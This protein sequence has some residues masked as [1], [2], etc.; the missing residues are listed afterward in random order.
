MLL[1]RAMK[2]ATYDTQNVG[3]FGLASTSYLHFT[4]PI[5]RYPDLVVHRAVRAL[6]AKKAIDK[7]PGALGILKKA[8]PRRPN[9]NGT[10][11]TWSEKSSI[12]TARSTCAATSGRP[13]PQG[14]RARRVGRLRSGR[15]PVRRRP[16]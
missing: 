2:Q 8:Q 15:E 16:R 9:A 1:L 11:W 10:R 14:D 6:L 12:S 3:H 5:R 13:T 7:S 4:S